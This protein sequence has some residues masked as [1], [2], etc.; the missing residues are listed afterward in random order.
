MVAVVGEVQPGAEFVMSLP[1][2]LRIS[3]RQYLSLSR[4]RGGHHLTSV[5][6]IV[7]F[8]RPYPMRSVAS[9]KEPALP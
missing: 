3:H 5:T 7:V 2:I 1:Q 8:G 6:G 9:V 4:C